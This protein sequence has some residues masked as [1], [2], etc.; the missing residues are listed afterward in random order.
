MTVQSEVPCLVSHLEVKTIEELGRN[1]LAGHISV[2]ISYL[3]VII[4][5]HELILD[6]FSVRIIF[7][8]ISVICVRRIT[9]HLAAKE[10]TCSPRNSTSLYIISGIVR[11]IE[12]SE[13]GILEGGIEADLDIPRRCLHRHTCKGDFKTFVADRT[14]VC[15]KLVSEI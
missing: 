4:P 10:T 13:P 9:D 3:A 5:V 1:A 12:F 6:R 7:L 8:L 15:H 2:C 14:D 11:S